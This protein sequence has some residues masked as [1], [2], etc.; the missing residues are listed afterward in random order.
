MNSPPTYG[1]LFTYLKTRIRKKESVEP[2]H[3][4]REFSALHGVDADAVTPILQEFGGYD[5][6]EV[7]FNVVD[8]I[9][10]EAKIST[11]VKTPE[12]YAVRHGLYCRRE[13]G[14]LAEC[15]ADAPNAT[16]DLN[17]AVA[18]VRSG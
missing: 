5:D 18:L 2:F 8:R 4:V 13:E 3:L 9:P 12:Q 16:P 6:L 11:P 7:L 14:G 15:S 1:T 17:R 10:E